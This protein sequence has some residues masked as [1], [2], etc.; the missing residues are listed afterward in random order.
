MKKNYTLL[1]GLILLSS[2]GF[3]QGLLKS[4]AVDHG[5][6]KLTEVESVPLV[7]KATTQKALGDTVMYEDFANSIPAGWTVTNNAG[8]SNNWIW[9]NTA[10]GGQY[11]TGTLALNSTTGSNGYMALPCDL[12]NTPFPPGGP[13]AMD[14]WFTSPSFSITPQI[15]SVIV[16]YEHSQ[17][18]CCSSLNELVLEVSN[19]GVTWTA[20]DGTG[21]RN[22]NTATPNAETLEINVSSVLGYQSTGYVRFRS[23]GNSHYYWMIDDVLVYEGPANNMQLEGWD[24][25]FHASY[26]ITPIYTILPIVN[27]PAVTY[28]GYSLNAGANTQT[29]VDFNID[30][31]NDSTLAGGPGNGVVHSASSTLGASVLSQDRDTANVNSPFFTFNSGYYRNRM[32]VT[33]DSVN[34]APGDAVAEYTMTLTADTTLALDRGEAFFSISS[35][36]SSYVGGGQDFDAMAALMVLDSQ[37]TGTV[38]ATSVSIFIANRTENAGVSIS[39][40]VWP[41]YEDSATLNAAVAAPVANSPFSTVI[42]T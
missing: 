38:M 37:L 21:G 5:T 18:Y 2:I 10:P 16:K 33:S 17:R 41:F 29:N 32:Y 11:S 12:Y 40:R 39:P 15:G 13:I 20:F 4:N 36:P 35:G 8:N 24:M 30:V 34:Q 25:K 19:D 26:D 22:P 3:S 1:T 28:E 23:T 14:V 9:S 31:I 27:I 7:K 42:D 6:P